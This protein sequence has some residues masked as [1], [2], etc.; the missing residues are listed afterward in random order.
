MDIKTGWTAEIGGKWFKFDIGIDMSDVRRA[1]V[2]EGIDME[3][4]N[5][6]TSNEVFM[7]QTTIAEKYSLVHQMTAVPHVFRTDEN[8]NKL[9]SL[10]AKIKTLLTEA[11]KRKVGNPW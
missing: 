7:L 10:T 8:H 2:D 9:A 11:S 1:F 6:L 4:A 5:T 3:Y